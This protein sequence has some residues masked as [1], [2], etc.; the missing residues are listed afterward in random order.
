ML[1]T[2]KYRF[3]SFPVVAWHQITRHFYLT[4][5]RQE[6]QTVLFVCVCLIGRVKR[7]FRGFKRH[8]TD[9]QTLYTCEYP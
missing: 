7:D 2:R 6:F 9:S 8:F 5:L 1:N 3:Y 4:F